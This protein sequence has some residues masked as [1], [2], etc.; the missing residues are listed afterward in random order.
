MTGSR[1]GMA[2]AQVRVLALTAELLA[3]AWNDPVYRD[4]VQ[5][6]V[7]PF[8]AMLSEAVTSAAAEYGA[9]LS[10]EETLAL[11]TLIRTFQMGV[12]I[13]RLAGA[14]TGHAELAAAIDGR[15][16]STSEGVRDARSSA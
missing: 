12:L 10:Q 13:E 6:L 14:D 5:R 1:P 7:V 3:K 15:L 8:T 16:C 4:G 2:A 9:V 11:A